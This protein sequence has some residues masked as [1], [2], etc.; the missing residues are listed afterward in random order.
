VSFREEL[1][2]LLRKAQHFGLN[3]A[4]AIE[5]GQLA[6]VHCAASERDPD[7]L[8][9]LVTEWLARTGATRLVIDSVL[10]LERT[11]PEARKRGVFAALLIALRARG[12]TALFIRETHK[13]V[14][15]ELDYADSALELVAEN[16]VLLRSARRPVHDHDHDDDLGATLSVLKMRETRHDS[17]AEPYALAQGFRALVASPP[18]ASETP[19]GGAGA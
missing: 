1:P 10:E 2:A 13:S 6:I 9:G 17:T 18:S 16:V 11:I 15:D 8:L 5:S 7:V 3:M 4:A 14:G 19:S 12:V